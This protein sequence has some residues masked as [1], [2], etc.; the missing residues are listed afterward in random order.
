MSRRSAL[1]LLACLV[2]P[3]AARATLDPPGFRAVPVAHHAYPISALAVAPDGRLFA[4]IQALGQTSGTTPGSAEIR[5]YSAY[6]TND[7]SVLDEG[8]A[9]ATVPNVRA[10]TSEEGLLGIALA[11]DFAT[12]KL[13]YVYLTTTDE[14]VN[15]QVWAYRENAAGTGDFL[16]AVKT[17]LEPP[18][19][20]TARNGGA[21]VFGVDDCLYV[22]VGD[23]GS[24]GRWNA[25]LPVGTDPIQSAENAA[26]CT[27]VCLG[28]TEYPARTVANDGLP[29]EAG[30]VLRLAVDGPSPAE[31]APGAPLSAGPDVFAAGMRNPG[32]AAVHPLT[33]QLWVADRPDAQSGEIDVLDLGS[34]GGWPCIE[35]D[36]VASA[37]LVSCLSG[38]APADV[39]ANHP[40]WRRPIVTHD[41]VTP[42]VPLGLAVYTGLGYPA[43]FYGDVFYLLRGS[44]RIYRVDLEP[45]CFLPHPNG[46]TPLPFHDSTED[47]DFTAFYDPSGGTNPQTVSFPVLV[48]T[49][50]GPNPLG[51]QVLYVAGKQGNSSALDEDSVVFRIE[52]ATAFTPYAGPGGRVPD[53]CFTA[54]V[55]SGGGAGGAAPYA[56]ENP[57]LR[58]TCALPGSPCPGQPDGTPCD[59]G[60]PS[61]GAETCQAG[62]CQHGAPAPDGTACGGG[63]DCHAPA[64]CQAGRCAA[65]PPLPDGTACAA[66]DPCLPGV[67]AAGA[68]AASGSPAR[69]AVRQLKIGRELHGPGSGSLA[70]SG[71][72]QAASPLAPEA[73]D[74]L[75]LELRHGA[76]L[77]FT[78]TLAHP[79]TDRFW[80]RRNGL[81][82]YANRS[83]RLSSVVLRVQR[84]GTVQ[85]D[86]RGHRLAFAGLDAS[87]VSPRLV[88]G[89]QCFVADLTGACTLDAK[90]LR[91]RP[92]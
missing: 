31:P 89:R 90:K 9:W 79:A 17:S 30:K 8:S 64:S 42:P 18:A 81:V 74:A 57:F 55:Y 76:D 45:P 88:I 63:D 29:N 86:I 5:V 80:K 51:Q 61:N 10:T 92:R 20:A 37:S 52:Y 67:C 68:C 73:T 41:A 66:G 26:L 27:N 46:V 70:L 72:F 7:G 40:A 84:F 33:G 75:T 19:E 12:S 56:Y 28:T 6:A 38:L 14:L 44:D 47:G 60:D 58:P 62:V 78:G 83:D 54:G 36:V 85:V 2:A 87:A 1:P 3:G 25:Q 77:M 71:W 23:N 4:A 11:P 50:Q 34:N 69:L 21:L 43:E 65:G 91:C 49:A 24:A 35:G 53:T 59:D 16:G 48:A 13:V 15:Q 39:Y 82:R 22:G 32:S